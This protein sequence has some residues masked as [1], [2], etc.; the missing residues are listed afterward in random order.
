MR[1]QSGFLEHCRCRPL[2]VLESRLASERGELLAHDAIA[3]LWFVAEREERLAAACARTRPRDSE[4]IVDRHERALAT[5]WWPRER[6]VMAYVAAEL[7][8]RDEDLRRV[9]DERPVPGIA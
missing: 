6:A 1:Q 9:R 5:T 2:D 8:E 7:R 3:Q 4:H